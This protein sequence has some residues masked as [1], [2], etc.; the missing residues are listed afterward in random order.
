MPAS[1]TGEAACLSH[2]FV[3]GIGMASFA[4][5]IQ[6]TVPAANISG[7]LIDTARRFRAMWGII[8]HAGPDTNALPLF[9]GEG[10]LM[11]SPKALTMVENGPAIITGGK[12][13]IKHIAGDG[14][15]GVYGKEA[16]AK[17]LTTGAIAGG[18]DRFHNP[19]GT[20]TL[21]AQFP[22]QT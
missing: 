6:V 1:F 16:I 11:L 7:K 20:Q 2:I 14:I 9:K 17:A 8:V 12:G 5:Q 22:D 18:I 10:G 4:A 13:G 3:V 15:N 19:F 21:H